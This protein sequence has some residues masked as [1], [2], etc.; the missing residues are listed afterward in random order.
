MEREMIYCPVNLMI[1][2][3]VHH[4]LRHEW[5]TF[6]VL[7]IIITFPT[8]WSPGTVIFQKLWTIEDLSRSLW[9]ANGPFFSKS[10]NFRFFPHHLGR[11]WVIFRKSNYFK[12][13]L[14][15]Y[16]VKMC[17]Q[18]PM[19]GGGSSKSRIVTLQEIFSSSFLLSEREDWKKLDKAVKTS[20]CFQP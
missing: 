1:F 18:N 5:D 4:H 17:F 16:S 11:K 8:H 20:L 13:N 2:I 7:V 9:A 3:P 15:I 14:T 6:Q 10:E 19:E 12:N